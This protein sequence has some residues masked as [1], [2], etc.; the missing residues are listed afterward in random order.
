VGGAFLVPSPSIEPQ[1]LNDLAALTAERR[2]PHASAEL[3]AS[4]AKLAEAFTPASAFGTGLRHVSEALNKI[5][6][7]QHAMV[8]TASPTPGLGPTAS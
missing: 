5:A 4:L 8:R 1:I 3:A 2:Y 7:A 6:E